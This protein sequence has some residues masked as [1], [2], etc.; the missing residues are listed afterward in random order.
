MA[1][2]DLVRELLAKYVPDHVFEASRVLV[3]VIAPYRFYDA[4]WGVV[5]GPPGRRISYSH[6]GVD[7][8]FVHQLRFVKREVDFSERFVIEVDGRVVADV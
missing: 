5:W 3:R 6:D 4:H 7:L 2:T 8:K 1:E